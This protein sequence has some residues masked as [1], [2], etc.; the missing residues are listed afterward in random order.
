MGENDEVERRTDSSNQRDW[1]TADG[2]NNEGRGPLVKKFRWNLK[3]G[4]GSQLTISK[5][6]GIS[7]LQLQ[8]IELYQEPKWSRK[9]NKKTRAYRKRARGPAATLIL[10]Q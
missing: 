4:I 3:A 5:K 1:T 8:E 9:G 6:I 10:T 7:V 2:L